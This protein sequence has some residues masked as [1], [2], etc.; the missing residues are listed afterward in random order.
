RSSMV[1]FKNAADRGNVREIVEAD[2]Q[3]HNV[4]YRAADN[5]KLMVIVQNLK[6]QM[7]RYR[8]EYVKDNANYAQILQEHA[9]IIA[10]L[11]KRDQEYVR[12]I[13]HA[14][15]ENQVEAVRSVIRRQES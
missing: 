11:E 6:E 1:A 8:Y 2:E 14:H 9:E 4:I 15:L 5:P 12:E 10:G 3:F 7:Y 13:M